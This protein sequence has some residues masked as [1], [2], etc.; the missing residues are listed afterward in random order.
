L[1]F[2]ILPTVSVPSLYLFKPYT[3]SLKALPSITSYSYPLTPS[4][5]PL[6]KIPAYL[7]MA[8]AVYLL[9]PVTIL[10]VTPAI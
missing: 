8:I 3:N 10:T 6:S 5:H 7:A 2:Y 9:S 4:F 1:N